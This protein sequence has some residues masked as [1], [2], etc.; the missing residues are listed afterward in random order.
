MEM[1]NDQKGKLANLA[2]DIMQMGGLS[3]GEPLWVMKDPKHK[4][5]YVVLEGNRRITALK[6]MENPALADGTVV[7][8]HF[9]NLSQLFA[10]KPIRQFE[11]KVFDD[12]EEA[13]PWLRRRHLSEASGVGLQRW[14]YLAK[15]RAD[16]AHGLETPR[17][18]SVIELLGDD[19][20]AW[21]AIYGAL[22]TRW[23]TVDRVLNTA[24]MDTVLGVTF[25]T[26]K[27]V[28][29]FENGNTGAGRKLLW[30]ML[31]RM[32]SS[33]FEFA[34]VEKADD[35]E[36][37]IGEFAAD[38]VKAIPK[39]R[40]TVNPPATISKSS[41]RTAKGAPVVVIKTRS[42]AGKDHS[43]R[44]TLAPKSGTRVFQVDAARLQAIYTECKNIK[45][46]KNRNAAA[47]LLRVFIELSSE[48]LLTK[49]R[50]PIPS[51]YSQK[52]WGDI[53]LRLDLKIST[54]LHYLDP[55]KSTKEFQQAR[56]SLDASSA[57]A[58][59]SIP[60]LH[61]YFHNLNLIPDISSLREAWDAWESYLK[62]VH[63][64]LRKP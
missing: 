7:E 35:R 54:V 19:S 17:F 51:R 40:A 3:P 18:L 30:R 59:F 25:D 60:T 56:Q 14:K 49:R 36:A 28:V 29:K 5:Q 45:L 2:G 21:E 53:G 37:F 1:V 27:R 38:S 20:E 41:T 10:K 34:D 16:K 48:A 39:T 4:A 24:G 31:Q 46:S 44:P 9:K 57:S 63:E 43:A 52:N 47:L 32:A 8:K 26:R 15:A 58:V 13:R 12:R 50:I 11:A 6:L 64:D 42:K 23:S 22:D 62:A 61:G 55:S 33:D